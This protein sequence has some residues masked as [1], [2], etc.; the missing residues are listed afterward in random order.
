MRKTRRKKYKKQEHKIK[1]KKKKTNKKREIDEVLR[2]VN[3]T[4]SSD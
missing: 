2:G 1:I 3:N 4:E